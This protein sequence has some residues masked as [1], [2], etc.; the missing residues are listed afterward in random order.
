MPGQSLCLNIPKS[1]SSF[2]SRFFDGADW[3]E[4]RRRC[5]LGRLA[6]PNW[7]S[8][9]IVRRIK[10]YGPGWG[11][12]TCRFRDHHAGYSSLPSDLRRHPKLCALR[13]LRGWYC[14]YYLYYTRV[15]T[16][17]LLLRA[18]RLLVGGDATAVR[19]SS[20]GAILSRHRQAF[21]ERFRSEDA[22]AGSIGNLSVEFVVWFTGTVRLEVMMNELVGMDARPAAP[23]GFLTFRAITILFD[24]PGKVFRVQ[25]D[26]RDEYFASGRYLR[27]VRCDFFLD[28]DRLADQLCGVMVD[29]LGYTP[30]IVAFL[31]ENTGRR[32]ESRADRKP[33]IM[34]E[35]DAG[36]WF[37]GTIENEAI[38]ENYLLPLAGS[39]V[40]VAR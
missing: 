40:P 18:V 30:E 21:L 16:D 14:S 32:N 7:T 15:M 23:T 17:T 13:E 5:G 31:K 25:A 12:L 1:G 9:Q 27:D 36:G 8:I 34:G 6:V 33:R 2:T 37:A 19:D 11:N 39:H 22:G 10:R 4:L 38:Y 29:E 35:L 3:L 24:D 28:F 20:V 26:E